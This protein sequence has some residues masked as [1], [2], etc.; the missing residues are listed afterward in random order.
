MASLKDV[1]EWLH[2]SKQYIF[3]NYNTDGDDSL[4]LDINLI[5][6]TTTINDENQ[7]IKI[8]KTCNEWDIE[9]PETVYEFIL[10]NIDYYTVVLY[11]FAYLD[12]VRV[13]IEEINKS[14]YKLEYTLEKGNICINTKIKIMLN[15]N[16][17][18]EIKINDKYTELISCFSKYKEGTGLLSYTRH[19]IFHIYTRYFITDNEFI[20]CEYSSKK[21]IYNNTYND[22]LN[23]INSEIKIPLNRW[24]KNNFI[25]TIEK[26]NKEYESIVNNMNRNS[27]ANTSNM[28][29]GS[30]SNIFENDSD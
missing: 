1:P 21:R 20:I 28:R 9:F 6:I 10:T 5:P 16:V 23:I 4:Q 3:Y 12:N 15:K 17:L 8:L 7:L 18:Y 22:L 29:N 13:L 27:N 11:R 19:E 2:K 25:S 30:P 24:N 26:Y 14:N